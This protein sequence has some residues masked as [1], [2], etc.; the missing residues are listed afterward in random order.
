V[1]R[2]V[3]IRRFVSIL[4]LTVVITA[5]AWAGLSAEVFGGFQRRA[6]D[7][8]FPG[9]PTDQRVVVVGV[10]RK[11]INA[12]HEPLPWPRARMAELTDRLAAAG[13]AVIV[14]DFVFST[15]KPGDDQ[16][17]AAASRAG[18]VVFAEEITKRRPGK[19]GLPPFAV[20]ETGVA[21]SLSAS[22]AV[23]GHAQVNQDPAD[24]VVRGITVL[25]DT[26][27]GS[28][29]PALSLGAVVAYRGGNPPV[30]LRPNGVQI[31]DRFIP[32]DAQRS[33]T[34]NFSADLSDE[35][36]A[37]SAVDV[38]QGNIDRRRL[39]GKIVFVGATDPLAGDVR[40]AP[41]NKS[42]R[43]PGVFLHANGA[44]TMLTATYLEP[45]GTT[46]TLIWVALLSVLVAFAILMLPLWLSPF[47]TLLFGCGYIVLFFLRFDHGQVL[48]IVYPLMA[49]VAAFIGALALRYFVEN[50][51]RRRVTALF[52]QYVPETVAQ[53][54]VDE[55]RVETAA[56]GQRLDM[57]VLF[58]DLRGFTALSESL[59]PA[60]VRVM[61][62]HYY[63][64]VTELVLGMRGTLMKYV[65]DEVFA[66][67]GAPIPT[68]DHPAQAL[69]CAIAIQ[70]LTPEL[71][72]ELLE[73]DA[74]EVS[75]GIG[76]NTGEAVAAHFGGRRRRQY[77][78]VGDTVN[79]G[80]RLCSAAGR[81]EI[82][83]SD[84]V[85]SRVP[86]PPPVEPVGRVQL[87]GVSREL[88]LWRVVDSRLGMLPESTDTMAGRDADEAD[89]VGESARGAMAATGETSG[90]P[91]RAR[92]GAGEAGG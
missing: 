46:T 82:I 15:E 74:P 21:E 64:R 45:V 70:E 71:N 19:D 90:E 57:T 44:N 47:L 29:L 53:R 50:R 22:A 59:S 77:D 32:T 20:K 25:Y 31:G 41:T 76:L 65:G 11:S 2:R 24:G 85:L 66:V 13:A 87:K 10:D 52:S 40:L 12:F 63:D 83:L 54:L 34:L 30:I 5:I 62:D 91:G 9:A 58:C 75:F 1:K 39:A 92:V 16:F 26:K 51:Q 23:V 18:N 17:A 7:A 78:V 43:L 56:G 49:I 73:R 38:I 69:A 84:Q 60:T 48:N 55:D 33:M 67:W 14:F 6:T 42:S 79:V 88:R 37:I 80:A 72:R 68:S 28:F 81:G 27:S 3:L 61:L 4:L 89:E 35:S 8:L 86:S 36:N